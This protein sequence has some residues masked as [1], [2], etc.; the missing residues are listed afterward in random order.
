M[1]SGHALQHKSGM[2]GNVIIVALAMVV[3]QQPRHIS[4]D[5]DTDE[6]NL[7]R[8]EDNAGRFLRTVLHLVLMP[9]AF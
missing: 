5:H 9:F 6:C 8:K 3:R 7:L 1:S 4:G 2:A